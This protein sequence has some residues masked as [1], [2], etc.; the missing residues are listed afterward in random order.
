MAHVKTPEERGPVGAWA[1]DAR[2]GAELSV[3]QVIEK[4][5]TRYH[6]AT[7]RKV[8]GGS[9]KA[10]RRMLRELA[11]VYHSEPPGLAPEPQP[12][13]GAAIV[14]AIDRLTTAIETQTRQQVSGM[15][16]LGDVLGL[17]LHRLGG[18]PVRTT[19]ERFD[20]QSVP[21]R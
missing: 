13:D 18:L 4:L 10:G 12:A 1:Y 19:D 7:L 5:P 8:E 9:A 17:V 21:T 3:E 2:I 11:T 15:A 14:A 6:P 16:G 20:Q